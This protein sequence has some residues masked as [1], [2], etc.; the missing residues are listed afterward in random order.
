MNQSLLFK[1]TQIY[2]NFSEVEANFIAIRPQKQEE[3]GTI[4]GRAGL[5]RIVIEEVD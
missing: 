1:V 4:D 3:V 5:D 2:P